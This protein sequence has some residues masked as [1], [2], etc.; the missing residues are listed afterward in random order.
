[1]G[2][3]T[4]NQVNQDLFKIP[5]EE[6]LYEAVEKVR[7]DLDP[8]LAQTA[9]DYGKILEA[10]HSLTDPINHFFDNVIVNDEDLALRGNRYA[11]LGGVQALVERIGDF[12]AL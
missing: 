4:S 12:R 10:L 2:A 7:M 6:K 11:L 9:P 3:N 5:A 1:M 8:M